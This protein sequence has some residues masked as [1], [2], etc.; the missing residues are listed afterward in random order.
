MKVTDKATKATHQEAVTLDRD[1]GPAARHDAR[2]ARRASARVSRRYDHG[3][4]RLPALRRRGRGGHDGRRPGRAAGLADPGS[5]PRHAA[6]GR[7]A[8]EMSI[9]IA[10]AIRKLA[11]GMATA[12]YLERP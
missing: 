6:R 10:P 9:A 11:G 4:Q 3:R 2:Q 7:R 12:A 1:E 5:V 8:E